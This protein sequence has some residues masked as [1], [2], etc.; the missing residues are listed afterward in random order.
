MT[1]RETVEHYVLCE[2]NFPPETFFQ[3]HHRPP[4][5]K[6][7]PHSKLS[8]FPPFS[9]LSPQ[10]HRFHQNEGDE[11]TIP[12]AYLR[13]F[14][15]AQNQNFSDPQKVKS[16]FLSSLKK[17]KLPEI[18]YFITETRLINGFNTVLHL[19][20]CTR[21]ILEQSSFSLSQH[22]NEQRRL[23]IQIPAEVL[24]CVCVTVT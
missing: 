14:S 1:T 17:K 5:H 3:S 23:L 10:D 11:Q 20:T 8:T 2:N 13:F 16:S 9:Q 19:S 6:N 22:H 7:I 4:E 24:Q 12:E 21:L 18:Y 15:P